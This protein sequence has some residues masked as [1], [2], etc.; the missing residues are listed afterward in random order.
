M[1][2]EYE[3]VP[4]EPGVA[5]ALMNAHTTSH[6]NQQQGGSNIKAPPVERSKL[7]SLCP[8]ADWV[9]FMSRWKSFKAATNLPAPRIVHHLLG[10]LDEEVSKLVYNETASPKIMDE[11][12]LLKLIER[13]AVKPENMWLMRETLHSMK[14]DVGEPITSFAARLKGQARLCG[15]TKEVGCSKDNCDGKHKL[16]FTEVVV[17]G[18]I[19]RG[20]ADP[21]IKAT[22][23]GEVEQHT[24]L[25]ELVK[26]IQAKEYGR[27][28]VTGASSSTSTVGAVTGSK[29]ECPNCGRE[30]AKG[31]TWKEHW[32]SMFY[33]CR[34]DDSSNQM[35][36]LMVIRK[37]IPRNSGFSF[38]Q[39]VEDHA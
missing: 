1:P 27:N 14:Q 38:L 20:L 17:M 32:L 19:V 26:L 13:V 18:D 31:K 3:T 4:V 36:S 29:P 37:L 5:A 10:C 25:D 21:E 7:Q 30:H 6:Q 8:K 24:V 12:T 23:L 15:F 11:L 28:S 39:S 22:V 9:V 33:Y 35:M 2:C 16:D 34:D